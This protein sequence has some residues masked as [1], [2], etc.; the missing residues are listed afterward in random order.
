MPGTRR[1]LSAERKSRS[2]IHD[3]GPDAFRYF[4]KNDVPYWRLAS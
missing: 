1:W 4:A 3:H 2:K